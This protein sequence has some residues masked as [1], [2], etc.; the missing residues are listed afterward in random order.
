MFYNEDWNDLTD[1]K[2]YNLMKFSIGKNCFYL[3]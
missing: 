2:I 3:H 1:D